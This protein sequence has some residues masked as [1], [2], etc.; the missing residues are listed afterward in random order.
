MAK[1]YYKTLGVSSNASKSQ[2]KRAYRKLAMK[3]HPDK[4]N[5]PEAQIVF[6][7]INEAYSFLT[8]EKILKV[9][10]P[11]L[12]KTSTRKSKISQEELNKRMEWARRYGE[13]KKIKEEKINEI[14]YYKIQKSSLRW[15]IPTI[16]SLSIFFAFLIL[17]DFKIL[18]TSSINVNLITRYVDM[19]SKKLVLKFQDDDSN[20][21]QFGISFEDIKQINIASIKNYT[22][23]K[24]KLFRQK[25]H[26]VLN[27]DNN[28]VIIFNHY[29][30]YKIFYFYFILLLLPI[31]TI[32]SKGPNTVYILSSYVIS[33]VSVLGMVFLL[34]TLVI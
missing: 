16:N 22:C 17:L 15:I 20:K 34:L 9:K 6:I 18:P 7:E 27:F 21:F 29:C 24:S 33:S 31:I 14:T 4:N 8:D 23:Q 1:N 25:T 12:K 2:I 19:D 26:M 32:F 13:Y 10:K 11:I 28:D 3:Y 5:S 30:V